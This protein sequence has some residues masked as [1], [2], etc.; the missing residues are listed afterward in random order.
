MVC[1]IRGMKER[2]ANSIPRMRFPTPAESPGHPT[3]V[4]A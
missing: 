4:T 2:D 1:T 3:A